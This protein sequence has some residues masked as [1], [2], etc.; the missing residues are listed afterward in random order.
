MVFCNIYKYM[1]G[2]S[3]CNIQCRAESKAK[4][5]LPLP[6]KIFFY[7]D[8]F[9]KGDTFLRSIWINLHS[10]VCFSKSP[11][12]HLAYS[13][14][15]SYLYKLYGVITKLA[16]VQYMFVCCLNLHDTRF[17]CHLIIFILVTCRKI[18]AFSS[19]LKL[20]DKSPCWYNYQFCVLH[21]LI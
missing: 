17:N 5:T 19:C 14:P 18:I 16:G 12:L 21:V 1:S 7:K 13:K 20:V 10:I 11:K 6:K 4:N 2:R 15:S 8:I 9:L 3:V